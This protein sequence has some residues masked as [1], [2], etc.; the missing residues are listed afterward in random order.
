MSTADC[1]DCSSRG[2]TTSTVAAAVGRREST[3]AV[4]TPAR[5]ITTKII[6]VALRRATG[7]TRLDLSI[8]SLFSSFERF[9]IQNQSKFF[10]IPRV[11]TRSRQ[12]SSESAADCADDADGLPVPVFMLLDAQERRAIRIIRAIRGSKI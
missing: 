7:C 11:S 3:R 1:D 5:R 2:R 8:F 6:R 9:S 10:T 12:K 4:K